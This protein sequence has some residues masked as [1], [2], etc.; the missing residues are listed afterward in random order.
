MSKDKKIQKIVVS[1]F[2]HKDGKLLI[3]RRADKESFLPGVYELPG[4]NIEFG[5]TTEEGL[6]REIKEELHIDVKIGEPFYV[7]TTIDSETQHTIEIDYFA[8]LI[9]H[10]Q[11]IQLNPEDHSEFRWVSQDDFLNFFKDNKSGGESAKK[12]FAILSKKN[13]YIR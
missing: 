7:F 5:E 8:T 6:A 3:A 9:D 13:D 1:A 11:D 2:I 10:N 4:G 12:G